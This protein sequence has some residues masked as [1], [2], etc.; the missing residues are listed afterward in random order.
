MEFMSRGSL[1]HQPQRMAPQ[2]EP[3]DMRPTGPASKRRPKEDMLAVGSRIGTNAI[4][5]IVALLVAAV[6]WFIYSSAPASQSSYVDS[7]K[8]Q[9]VF[10]NSGQV[11]FGSIK[12]L[13]QNYL[14]LT[15]VYYLQSNN[16]SNSSSSSASNQNISLVKL[17]CELHRPYDT[18]VINST[19]VTF[20]ENLQA[21]GQVAKAVAQFQQQNPDGQKCSTT[22]SSTNNSSNPQS[23]ASTNPEAKKP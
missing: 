11:Y 19:Q 23:Q 13:N 8:L 4:L 3:A 10:L 15:N 1:T 16:S 17:G 21:D 22:S 20:W 7:G 14:V 6:V 5:F 2:P 18:M 9:A 12:E